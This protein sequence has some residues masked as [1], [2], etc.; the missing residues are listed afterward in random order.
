MAVRTE[1]KG[2]QPFGGIIFHFFI[3][4][5]PISTNNSFLI[6]PLAFDIYLHAGLI[7]SFP[8]LQSLSVFVDFKNLI[9]S[10]FPTLYKAS[11]NHASY[12]LGP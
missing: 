9:F 11:V 5:R 6:H 12:S 4:L 1:I 3:L 2:K 8:I 10:I 7:F